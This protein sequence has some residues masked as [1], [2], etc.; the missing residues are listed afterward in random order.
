MLFNICLACVSS[1]KRICSRELPNVLVAKIVTEKGN[2]AKK[3]QRNIGQKV[4]NSQKLG[5]RIRLLVKALITP[6]ERLS[7]S[8]KP[9]KQQLYIMADRVMIEDMPQM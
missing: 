6:L 2:K 1:N 5:N 3:A 9:I 4:G 7:I 8:I